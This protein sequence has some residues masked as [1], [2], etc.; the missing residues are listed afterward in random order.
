MFA[1]PTRADLRRAA[2]RLGM[3]PDDAYLDAAG[4]VLRELSNA[5][6]E[7]DTMPDE[8]PAPRYARSGGMRPPPDENRFGAWYVKT[9]VKGA[10]TGPLAGRRVALKDNICLAGVP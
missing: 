5:Y 1:P 4:R 8:M 3:S 2:T 9:A 6:A 10:P 7:L